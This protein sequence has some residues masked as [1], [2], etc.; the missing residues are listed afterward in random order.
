[1]V[2]LYNILLQIPLFT[3]TK[4]IYIKYFVTIIL[5]VTSLLNINAQDIDGNTP[6]ANDKVQKHQI[7]YQDHGR[8]GTNVLWNLEDLKVINDNYS[9]EYAED[10]IMPERIKGIEHGTAYCYDMVGDSLLIGRMENR[11]TKMEYD[12]KEVWLRFPISYGDSV[13]GVFHGRGV[14]CERMAMRSIGHYTNVVDAT[15]TLFLPDGGKLD[16]VT[17]IKTTRKTASVFYPN[18]SLKVGL[19]PL[20]TDSVESLMANC[21]IIELEI[22]R[23]YAKGYR[24]PILE[25]IDIQMPENKGNRSTAFYC[26]PSTQEQ[27]FYDKTN[28]ETRERINANGGS[29]FNPLSGETGFSYNLYHDKNANNIRLEYHLNNDA[30]IEYGLYTIDGMVMFTSNKQTVSKGINTTHID[31]SSCKKGIYILCIDINGTMYS[32]KISLE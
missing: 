13:G 5:V 23:W 16:N 14:Y 31:T 2:M 21:K 1:M 17:R 4:K 19:S 22:Y 12:E 8:A 30:Q 27:L 26:S 10:P 3:M 29:T 9:V 18:D 20:T 32:E 6:R 15:G 7:E 25:M 11:L 24:Y 28:E